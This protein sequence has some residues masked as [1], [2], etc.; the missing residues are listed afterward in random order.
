MKKFSKFF[1]KILHIFLH[2]Y[3]IRAMREARAEKGVKGFGYWGLFVSV[4]FCH[5]SFAAGD[6]REPGNMPRKA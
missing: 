5:S 1:G 4:L 6:M 2:Q 3:F